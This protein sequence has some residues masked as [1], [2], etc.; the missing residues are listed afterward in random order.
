MAA[1]AVTIMVLLNYLPYSTGHK[2]HQNNKVRRF[3]TVTFFFFFLYCGYVGI[4]LRVP[5]IFYV[6]LLYCSFVLQLDEKWR[7]G[8]PN[9]HPQPLPNRQIR[10]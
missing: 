7:G 2:N 9:S 3:F 10:P 8:A 6:L 1:I 5:S 4:K